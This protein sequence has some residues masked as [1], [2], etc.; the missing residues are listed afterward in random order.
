MAHETSHSREPPR[1]A[2]TAMAFS[3]GMATVPS[4]RSIQA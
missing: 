4:V 1:A 3:I 2:I